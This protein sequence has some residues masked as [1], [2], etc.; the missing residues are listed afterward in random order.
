MEEKIRDFI[1]RRFS[2][3]KKRIGDKDSLFGSG[4]MDSIAH[5]QLISFLEKEFGVSFSMD[6]FSLENF[7]TIER[8]SALLKK[9]LSQSR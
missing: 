9:K 5:L 3:K 6:E 8:I 7:D 1:Q 4:A 2:G